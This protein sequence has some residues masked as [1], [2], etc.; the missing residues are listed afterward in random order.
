MYAV[1]LSLVKAFPYPLIYIAVNKSDH[2]ENF[3]MLDDV[4]AFGT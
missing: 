4:N 3:R 1:K 2:S